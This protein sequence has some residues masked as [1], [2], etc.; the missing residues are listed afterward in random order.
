MRA[1]LEFRL[2]VSGAVSGRLLARTRLVEPSEP[3]FHFPKVGIH[4]VDLN[5]TDEPAVAVSFG[6]GQVR[7]TSK[8][9]I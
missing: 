8:C 4:T 2:R 7:T 5:F 3:K 1:S 9:T 6:V